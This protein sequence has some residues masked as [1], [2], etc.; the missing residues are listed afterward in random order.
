M[1]N[2]P[3][4]Y[5]QSPD[6]VVTGKSVVIEKSLSNDTLDL[7][8]SNPWPYSLSD[9]L[10]NYIG[11]PIQVEYIQPN[12]KSSKKHGKLIVTGSNFIGIEPAGT[13]NLF[14][15]ELSLVKCVNVMKYKKQ[16]AGDGKCY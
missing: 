10:P 8:H 12:G 2:L 5:F 1:N 6:F 7:I 15:V 9:Y 16:S 4:R 14:I 3:E 11:K 13:E